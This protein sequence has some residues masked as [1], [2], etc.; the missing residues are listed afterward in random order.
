MIQE[1]RFVHVQFFTPLVNKE[2]LFFIQL[3]NYCIIN[4]AIS[5]LSNVIGI[6]IQNH[7]FYQMKN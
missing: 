1:V 6:L 3:I 4:T 5:L 7:W 2:L